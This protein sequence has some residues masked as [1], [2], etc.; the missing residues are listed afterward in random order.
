MILGIFGIFGSG[1]FYVTITGNFECF[2]YFNF[3]TNFLKNE[4]L[5]LKK[6]WE[7]FCCWKYYDWKSNKLIQDSLSK[8][9]CHKEHSFASI[10]FFFRKLCFSIRTCY[11]E[12]IWSANYPNI[13]VHTLWKHRTFIWGCFFPVS[14]LKTSAATFRNNFNTN[15]S[16]FMKAVLLFLHVH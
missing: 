16:C 4:N 1:I 3:E 15:V 2:Q 6:T 13:H 5:F 9:T 11:E 10:Y 14:I 12:L 8:W 7:S